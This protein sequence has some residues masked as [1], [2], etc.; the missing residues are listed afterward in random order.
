VLKVDLKNQHK[1]LYHPPADRP[2]LIHVPEMRFLMVD[3]A[4]DPNT[5]PDYQ[6]AVEAL[7]RIAYTLKFAIK[8]QQGIDYPVM[9]LE[10]LWWVPD[11]RQ[12][13]VDHKEEWQWTMM[14]MQPALVTR[15]LFEEARQHVQQKNPSPAIARVRLEA[16]EEGLSAQMLHLGPYADEGPTIAKLHAFIR[17]QGYR[18]RGKHHEIYLND[19]HRAAPEK[20][21]TIIRQPVD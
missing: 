1:G 15:D 3:G 18:P 10:G 14:L 5:S 9:A 16:F 13:S 7:Y 6:E 11:M 19:P 2:V 4:G 21:K 8:K 17:A 12:F 20:L